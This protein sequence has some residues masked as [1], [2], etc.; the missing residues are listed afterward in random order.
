MYFGK[1]YES[2]IH[3]IADTLQRIHLSVIFVFKHM[4]HFYIIIYIHF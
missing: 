2:S 3:D 1:K 4:I